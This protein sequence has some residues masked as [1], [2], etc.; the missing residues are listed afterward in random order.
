M[1]N[2]NFIRG[3]VWVHPMHMWM[4]YEIK[5][6]ILTVFNSNLLTED[7]VN[8]DYHVDIKSDTKF[9]V[10]S[11]IENRKRVILF[12]NEIPYENDWDTIFNS[13]STTV[14][15]YIELETDYL[16]FDTLKLKFPELNY[17]YSTTR[18]VNRDFTE[19]DTFS[20]ET[21]PYEKTKTEYNITVEEREISCELSILATVMRKST[22]PLKLETILVCRF[23]K[24]N[25]IDVIRKILSSVKTFFTF[26]CYRRNIKYDE[27]KMFGK[28]NETGKTTHFGNFYIMNQEEQEDIEL[29]SNTIE[30]NLL[31][32]KFPE[33]IQYIFNSNLYLEQIPES[34]KYSTK[35]NIAR[36]ILI[37]ASFES[38]I[39]R[40]FE[41]K[42]IKINE[43][44]ESVKTDILEKIEILPEE[45]RYDNKLKNEWK[46]YKKLIYD[47]DVNLS[48]KIKYAYDEFELI[49]PFVEDLCKLNNIPNNSFKKMG[50]TIQRHRNAFAHGSIVEVYE[51]ATLEIII[52]EWINYCITLRIVGYTD[53]QIFKI[54]NVVFER[55]RWHA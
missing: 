11:N 21:I 52:L 13:K 3:Y 33:L 40:Y 23:S 12:V 38:N 42:K 29:I 19:D 47:T 14:Y 6:S 30:Y 39:K 2:D 55:N 8:I 37:T 17:F 51:F 1:L 9:L 20:I 54:I 22:T 15:Y 28:N 16:Y 53:E 35:M 50:D 27:I 4:P 25:D 26:V 7:F 49:T 24:T 45:K 41:Y 18:G 5:K 44:R 48:R 34:K 36:F 32:P 31:E 43:K 10:G 46:F